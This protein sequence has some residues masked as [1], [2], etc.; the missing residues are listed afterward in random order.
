ME[1][2]LII[3]VVAIAILLAF[4]MCLT[5]IIFG[6]PDDKNMAVLPKVV[7]VFGL[8]LSFASVLVLPYDVA[9]SSG[10]GTNQRGGE[11][12]QTQAKQRRS[13]LAVGVC[14]PVFD[15]S[16]FVRLPSL[17]CVLQAEEF[18]SI[19]CGKLCTFWSR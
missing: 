15:H 5:L 11:T 16:F 3:V 10:G 14:V 18:V 7:T 1:V 4:G 2:F 9:N 13:R 8:W 19:L 12:G 17:F 6:H